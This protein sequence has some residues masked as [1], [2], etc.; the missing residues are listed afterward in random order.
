LNKAI[1]ATG[2][3]AFRME[4]NNKADGKEIDVAQETTRP[5]SK[6]ESSS[7]GAA[8]VSAGPGLRR[9]QSDSDGSNSSAES[10]SKFVALQPGLAHLKS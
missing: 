4:P 1:T 6:V 7:P 10:A 5:I 3:V 2:S 8:R 9:R